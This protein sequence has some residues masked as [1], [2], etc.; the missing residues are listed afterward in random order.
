MSPLD[1]GQ[2]DRSGGVILAVLVFYLGLGAAGVIWMR[3]R[4]DDLATVLLAA[5]MS[6]GAA[7]LAGLLAGLAVS[8]VSHALLERFHWADL[9]KN[10][11]RELL[12]PLTRRRALLVAALS[13]TMEEVF[14]RGALLPAMGFVLSS[15]LFG[16]LH[17][18]PRLL[19]WTAFALFAGF[20]MG[21]LY[22]WTGG[23]LAPVT[24]HMVVNGVQLWK[25]ADE[26]GDSIQPFG[27]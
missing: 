5:R 27:T 21:G 10:E 9:L 8:L 23:L 20:L 4:G 14:F 16:L 24:A 26:P 3:W 25:L 13:G 7:A 19:G 22:V 6:P 1:P 18:G 12:Q 2:G 11:V 17:C 15:L